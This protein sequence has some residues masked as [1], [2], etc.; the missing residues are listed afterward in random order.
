MVDNMGMK[1]YSNKFPVMYNGYV[2]YKQAGWRK[3]L[4]F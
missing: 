3:F 2:E 4:V 1:I